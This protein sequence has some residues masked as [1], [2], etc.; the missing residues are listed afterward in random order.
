MSR[1]RMFQPEIKFLS[2]VIEFSQASPRGGRAKDLSYDSAEDLVAQ[3]HFPS[4][5]FLLAS[6]MFEAHKEAPRAASLFAT[7]QRWLLSHAAVAHFFHPIGNVEPGL[8]RKSLG[9]LAILLGL[10]SRNTAYTFFDESMKYGVIQAID[11]QVV[12]HRHW[13]KPSLH[14][15]SLLAVWYNLHFKALDLLDGGDRYVEF[16]ARW[17]SLLPLIQPVVAH[18][19]FFSPEVRTPGPFYRIFNGIDSGGWMMDRLIASLDPKAFSKQERYLTDVNSIAYLARATGLSN[20]HT[21]R[22]LSEAHAIGVVGWDGRPGHSPMWIS[23]GFYEEYAQFQ[24]QKLIILESAFKSAL[25]SV[26]SASQGARK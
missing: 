2:H 24:A 5:V 18:A 1:W 11:D 19:L 3:S 8:S 16:S 7:Q 17:E 14:S 6:G 23:H 21:S 9:L 22:K 10:S 20:A 4:A 12:S 13:A 26:V 25:S 15:L